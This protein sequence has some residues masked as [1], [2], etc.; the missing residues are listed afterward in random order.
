MI[1]MMNETMI[2]VNDG[3]TLRKNGRY[4]EALAKYFEDEKWD[5]NLWNVAGVINCYRNLN[6]LKTAKKVINDYIRKNG[7]EVLYDDKK[8]AIWLKREF[9]NVYTNYY[10]E[11]DYL[12][13]KNRLIEKNALNTLKAAKKIVE[14]DCGSYSLSRIKNCLFNNEVIDKFPVELY[15]LIEVIDYNENK[16][17]QDILM[18]KKENERY[19][20][21]FYV[22]YIITKMKLL[23]NFGDNEKALEVY[24]SINKKLVTL[25]LE[26]TKSKIL[27]NLGREEEAIKL[28]EEGLIKFGKKYYIYSEIAD[29]YNTIDDYENALKY[30]YISCHNEKNL[31]FIY[32]I[33]K[34][35]AKLTSKKDGVLARK[36]LNLHMLIAELHKNDK[37]KL[38]KD[39]L[40]LDEELA[41]YRDNDI[42]D[43]KELE[44]ELRELWKNEAN[45]NKKVYSGEVSRIFEKGFGFIAYDDGDK[46]EEVFFKNKNAKLKLGDKV[47]FIVEKSYDRKKEEFSNIALDIK[48]I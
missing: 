19:I 30:Y 16:Y 13:Y 28:L 27:V 8:E 1:I 9:I 15:E 45:M 22:N 20:N 39:A 31:S 2:G 11:E 32:N 40:E 26:R 10:L 37:W 29:I 24:N 34:K 42:D 43:I 12:K 44:K 6:D 5:E 47:E 3:S 25:E 41:E 23:S 46:P 7:E 18:S 4:K 48:L 33:I 36:H 38:K 21:S 14:F 35:I 17:R